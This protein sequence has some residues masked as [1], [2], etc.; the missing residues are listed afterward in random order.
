MS[1]CAFRRRKSFPLTSDLGAGIVLNGKRSRFT[2]RN[3][4]TETLGVIPASEGY[5]GI[6][7]GA[8]I[9]TSTAIA[10]AGLKDSSHIF[11]ARRPAVPAVLI[12]AQ[13]QATDT[14]THADDAGH[15]PVSSSGG[16]CS[17]SDATANTVAEVRIYSLLTAYTLTA[18]S[19]AMILNSQA[20]VKLTVWYPSVLGK[21]STTIF[22]QQILLR[23]IYL[24]VSPEASYPFPAPA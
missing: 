11:F 17:L 1:S 12:E 7:T 19:T 8:V 18:C 14:E 20:A 15:G 2:W 24:S 3:D 13:T 9:L 6:R 22:T 21:D 5:P 10:E 16:Y 4:G 23:L